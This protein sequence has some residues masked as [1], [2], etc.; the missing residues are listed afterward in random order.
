MTGDFSRE[1]ETTA[2]LA[3]MLGELYSERI[4]PNELN[5]Y[6]EKVR[7]VDPATVREFAAGNLSGGD[8]IIVGDYKVFRE[9]L[10]KRFPN[11][12]IEVIKAGDLVLSRDQLIR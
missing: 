3:N 1:L 7:G 4:D 5:T 12:R 9:D 8:L 10:A 11:M 2:G 6:M